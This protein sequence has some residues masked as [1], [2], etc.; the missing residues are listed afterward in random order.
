[1]DWSSR[2]VTGTW[3]GGRLEGEP[4]EHRHPGLAKHG[5]NGHSDC[6]LRWGPDMAIA[7]EYKLGEEAIHEVLSNERRRRAIKL[8]KDHQGVADLR[9]LAEWIATA[10]SGES[11]PPKNVRQSV[12]NSLHQ[13]HLPKLDRLDIIDYDRDRK[14]IRLRPE[15]RTVDLY[16]EVI[17]PYG[18]T[19]STYYRTLA[20]ISLVTIIGLEL[21]PYFATA[22]LTILAGSIFLIILAGSTL[23]QLWSNQWIQ[24]KI[25][26]GA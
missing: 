6:Q 13:L 25:M 11:P 7:T 24:L 18:I 14:Q 4:I 22:N 19:W 9:S 16:M 15:A 20:L 17:T 5:G 8:L 3:G 23:Y 2:V 1:M 12:Y 21:N 10:E 26:F